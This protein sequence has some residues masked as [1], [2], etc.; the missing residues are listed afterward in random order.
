MNISLALILLLAFSL[1]AFIQIYVF[2][3]FS[4]IRRPLEPNPALSISTLIL[5]AVFIHS[6]MFIGIETFR[7][8]NLNELSNFFLERLINNGSP[9]RYQT[10]YVRPAEFTG[11]LIQYTLLSLVAASIFGLTFARLAAYGVKPF[12]LIGRL[13]YGGLY[14]VFRGFLSRNVFVS[15]VS[16][17]EI[18]GKTIIY[19]GTLEELKL[20]GNGEIE[21]VT[22]SIPRKSTIQ[23]MD[24]QKNTRALPDRAIG[25]KADPNNPGQPIIQRGRLMV[26]GGEISN[27]YFTK[28]D[29]RKTLESALLTALRPYLNSDRYIIERVLLMTATAIAA[30][31]SLV[32]IV[33]P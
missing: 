17:K 14:A 18:D 19:N 7:S 27:I 15:I 23:Y 13:Y 6:L 3:Y 1:P 2:Q 26:E 31:L 11:D 10:Q 30:L 24:D 33:H 5:G 28:Q 12:D 22:I 9:D 25:A 21:Y 4:R 32:I 16:S 8:G 29:F 20:K